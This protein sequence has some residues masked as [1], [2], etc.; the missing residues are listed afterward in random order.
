MSNSIGLSGLFPLGKTNQFKSLAAYMYYIFSDMHGKE[1][2][3]RFTTKLNT[4]D[5]F[6]TDANGRQMV[7]RKRNYRETYQYTNEEPI[8]GNYYP[9]TSKIR[10]NDSKNDMQFAVVTDRAQG[11]SSLKSG[12]VELMV[13]ISIDKI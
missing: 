2:I 7:R 4:G 12:Q 5:E 1:V 13:N 9:V 3:S 6:Y 11:G 10:L 8:S